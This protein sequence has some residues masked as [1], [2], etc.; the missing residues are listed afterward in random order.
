MWGGSRWYI[1]FATH[2][3][4][5]KRLLLIKENQIS[6]V[7]EF[8]AFLCMGRCNSQLTEVISFICISVTQG[9]YPL[10]FT[11][12]I[13]LGL[14]LRNVCSLMSARLQEFFSFLSALMAHQ[15]TVE[16]CICWWL[17]QF[18]LLTSTVGNISLFNTNMDDDSNTEMTMMIRGLANVCGMHTLS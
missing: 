17:W 14:T 13:P 1:S 9:Q 5:I 18:C 4:N 2:N 8:S 15:L 12:W 6:Q 3:L 11:S 16:G 7:E 10:F